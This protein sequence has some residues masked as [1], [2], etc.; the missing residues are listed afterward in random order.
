MSAQH[1]HRPRIL[2]FALAIT[3]LAGPA[4]AQQSTPIQQSVNLL[5]A[6]TRA[7]PACIE[8]T[9]GCHVCVKPGTAEPECSTPGI[10]CQPTAWQCKKDRERTSDSET[11]AKPQK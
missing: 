10:A 4:V 2:I 6:F 1:R 9:D 11:T 8:M 7:N 5:V 3:A